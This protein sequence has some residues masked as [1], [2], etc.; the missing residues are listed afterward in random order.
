MK[1]AASGVRAERGAGGGRVTCLLF[2]TIST[3]Y[4]YR[5]TGKAPYPDEAIM[6]EGMRTVAEEIGLKGNR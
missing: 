4:R 2:Y 1:G 5:K 6:H 3:I